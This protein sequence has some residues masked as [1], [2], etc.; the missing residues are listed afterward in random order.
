MPQMINLVNYNSELERFANK[1]DLLQ[2][3]R[4]YGIDGLEL[5]KV[6]ELQDKYLD[7]KMI[8]GIHLPFFNSWIDFYKGDRAKVLKEYGTEEVV[9]QVFGG[10]DKSAM[11]QKYW[12]QL[13]YANRLDVK[14]V[15][16]HICDISIEESFTGKFT[17]TDEEVIDT[18]CELINELLDGKDYKFDFLMENLWWPGLNYKN[19]R[20]TKRLLDGVRYER[21]GLMLD[22]GHLMN[23][24]EDLRTPE[25]G[26][27]YIKN[28]LHEHEM[29]RHYIKGIHLHQSLSGEFAK[30]VRK[31]KI[32]LKEDYWERMGQVYEAIFRL[33]EHKPFTCDGVQ[34]F[35]EQLQPKYVTYEFITRDRKEH[36]AYLKAIKINC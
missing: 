11:I 20:A 14:Y 21:K 23:T 26:L 10:V 27:E 8:I 36:E 16:F 1:N 24:N 4:K 32:E 34:E 17:R 15:V 7:Q 9:K 3:Y 31:Q 22:T 25:E 28:V 5:Q 33:D 30:E 35:I 19:P 6:H 2:F 29:V 18:S 12:E 13:E